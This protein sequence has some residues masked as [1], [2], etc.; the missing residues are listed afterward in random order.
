[1]QNLPFILKQ[2]EE[3][4]STA[5]VLYSFSCEPITK[6]TATKFYKQISDIYSKEDKLDFILILDSSGG[7][8][9]PAYVISKIL[10][11]YSKSLKIIVP[12]WA[13]SAATLIC[14]AAN[15]IIMTDIAELGPLDPQVRR[16]GEI[17]HH[18]VLDEFLALDAIRQDA[19]TT[20]DIMVPL[21][22][23]KTGMDLKDVLPLVFSFTSSLMRPIFEQINPMIHGSN[24]R[25]MNISMKYAERILIY[26]NKELDP[27]IPWQIVYGYPSHDFILDIKELKEIGFPVRE[28]NKEEETV[29]SPLI[30]YSQRIDLI[31]KIQMSEK[32]AINE[33][34][35]GLIE[36]AAGNTNKNTSKKRKA[37]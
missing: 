5:E 27:K 35:S 7:E 24:M 17:S 1:M 23:Q 26:W 14:L 37:D 25:T 6:S 36:A 30:K 9:G 28:T 18:A 3:Y 33:T 4:Y 34:T 22:I 20:F 32:K 21:L 12:R 31:G 15:E 8:I 13:K 2:I 10:K 19:I 11:T 16:S 29:V